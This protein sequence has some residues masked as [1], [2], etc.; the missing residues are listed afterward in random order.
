MQSLQPHRAAPARV[1]LFSSRCFAVA[2]ALAAEACAAQSPS[3]VATPDGSDGTG[4]TALEDAL[5]NSPAGDLLAT[6]E[7]VATAARPTLPGGTALDRALAAFGGRARVLALTSLDYQAATTRAVLSENFAPIEGPAPIGELA[8]RVRYDLGG[9]RVRADVVQH[10]TFGGNDSSLNFSIILAD[11]IGQIDGSEN[12]FS[13][14]TGRLNPRGVG[15]ES[16]E[17]YLVNPVVAL[18][19]AARQP[20]RVT[21]LA[22][23]TLGGTQLDRLQ[24]ADPAQPVILYIE[25]HTG[26]VLALSTLEDSPL[27]KDRLTIA[28]FGWSL[29][30]GRV[31][32]SPRVVGLRSGSTWVLRESRTAI[33]ENGALDAALFAM[34]TEGP[35]PDPVE[36]A[37]GAVDREH[38]I[39][40][41]RLGFRLDLPQRS[42][43]PIAMAS[44]AWMITGASHNS[45]VVEQQGGVVVME[46]PLDEDRSQALLAWLA[47]Q[48]P[49]KRVTYV[50]PTHHHEDHSG[51][52]RAFVAAGATV[53]IDGRARALYEQAFH[54]A[55]TAAPDALSR[56]PREPRFAELTGSSLTLPDAD[57][58][59]V[60]YAIPTDHAEDMVAGYL[61]KQR[62]I[63]ESDLYN[64]GATPG[65]FPDSMIW[66]RQFYDAAVGRGLAVDRVIGG[67][68]GTA[69]W[70][71]MKQDLGIP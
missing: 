60:L 34:T 23:V 40:L 31:M 47:G 65:A 52:L 44:G 54:A 33:V 61:P 9:G 70:A 64:P 39:D 7:Q 49:S 12:V 15:S 58:P 57:R 56:A 46:A 2:L 19:V 20:A 48:F 11:G 14:P 13:A 5:R 42:I 24:I 59:V 43:Q 22:P 18:Q 4:L 71:Q 36:Q 68:G 63:F 53:V 62:L 21:E 30:S 3:S 66:G 25:H 35:A 32:A 17:L 69:T 10:F 8:S 50:V 29:G 28:V 55:A 67:H 26:L 27:F 16:R 51:G 37:R 38:Q 41:A 6:I 45:F 1:T